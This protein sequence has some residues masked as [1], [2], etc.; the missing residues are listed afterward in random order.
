MCVCIIYIL[1]SG[2]PSKQ[3]MFVKNPA[4]P[5]RPTEMDSSAQIDDDLE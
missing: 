3:W 5:A 2:I 1:N 4:K